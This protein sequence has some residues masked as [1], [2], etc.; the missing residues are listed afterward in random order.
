MFFHINYLF[1]NYAEGLS[2]E[3]KLQP[4]GGGE[5]PK[6]FFENGESSKK[7]R[8]QGMMSKKICEF[9]FYF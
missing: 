5:N 8:Q 9:N 1:F 3:V 4:A 7:C 6:S 2:K